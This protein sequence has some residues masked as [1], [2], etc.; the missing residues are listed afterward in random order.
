MYKLSMI[1]IV[2]L[3]IFKAHN[4]YK[5]TKGYR[6]TKAAIKRLLV[7]IDFRLHTHNSLSK[8]LSRHTRGRSRLEH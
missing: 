7:V 5:H 2:Y 4:T 1:S 6:Q 8:L 3:I